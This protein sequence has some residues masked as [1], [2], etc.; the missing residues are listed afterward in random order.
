VSLDLRRGEIVGIAGVEGNGQRELAL[1][2]SGRNPPDEGRADVPARVG[3]IPQDRTRSGLV[4][5]FDLVE[6]VALAL[7]GDLR[8][9][10]GPFL[11]W[12]ALRART[13]DLMTRFDVRA[14]GPRTAAATL[15]GGNQQ[16]LLVA[17][18]LAVASDLLV[19]ENPTRGLDVASSSFV[20]NE[21]DRIVNDASGPGVAL[22]STDLDEVLAL[23]HRVLVMVRGRLEEVPDGERTR[24]G[25]G[26]RMVVGTLRASV[27]A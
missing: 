26:S 11:R 20:H 19:A 5:A 13:E 2:L 12:V 8:Y 3:F 24:E 17:R 6:N 1:T 27:H 15:S 14:A 22:I 16:R 10:S 7:H 21:L 4:A 23:S 18:E 9:R 25:V